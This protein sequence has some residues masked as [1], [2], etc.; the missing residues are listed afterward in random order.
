M[1][2]YFI[3]I[4]HVRLSPHTRVRL[5]GDG[6]SP[7][8]LCSQSLTSSKQTLITIQTPTAKRASLLHKQTLPYAGMSKKETPSSYFS[9]QSSVV[10]G[11]VRIG[12][13]A[14]DTKSTS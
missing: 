2:A 8:S 6:G 11:D 4:F 9:S 13:D 3:F 7:C 14:R 1:R 12:K 10:S 5:G